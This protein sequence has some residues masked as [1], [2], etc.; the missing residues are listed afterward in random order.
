LVELLIAT[1]IIF[2][3]AGAIYSAFANGVG[4]WRRCNVNR[5]LE[6]DVMINLTKM[7][8]SIRNTFKFTGISFKGTQETISFAALV[9]EGEVGRLSYFFDN[10]KKKLYKNEKTY[11]ELYGEDPEAEIESLS[12]T[13]LISDVEDWE[14]S[15]CYLDN[16]TGEYKWKETWEQGE[17]DT[18]PQAVRIDF[19]FKKD[20]N[21]TLD[22]T[23]AVYMP[24]GTGEQEITLSTLIEEI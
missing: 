2:L 14:F 4:V 22:F 23:K 11:I 5:K 8:I 24:I 10:D 15:Y 7:T 21:V 19:S 17:Q 12:G 9:N 20:E 6:R 1:S 13:V 18:I 16:A 3:V